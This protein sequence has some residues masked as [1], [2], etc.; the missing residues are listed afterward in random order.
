M[1]DSIDP[2]LFGEAQDQQEDTYSTSRF[3]C[4]LVQECILDR[5][6]K[7][8][9]IREFLRELSQKIEEPMLRNA[10]KGTDLAGIPISLQ[11]CIDIREQTRENLML[12]S[13][14]ALNCDNGNKFLVPVQ[15]LSDA[16]EILF[17]SLVEKVLFQKVEENVS[18]FGTKHATTLVMLS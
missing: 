4:R 17:R 14:E 18:F 6:D 10:H 9:A 15:V 2:Q 5:A 12:L 13:N 3:V 1:R 8:T 11:T 7:F 16:K